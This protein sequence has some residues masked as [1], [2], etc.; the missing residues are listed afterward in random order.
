[1]ATVN[2]AHITTAKQL[3]ELPEDFGP[4]ELVRGELI[5]MT[6]AGSRHNEVEVC[7]LLELGNFARKHRLGRVFSGDAGFLLEED[8]DTVR[9]PDV[10][11]V[12]NKRLPTEL[13][14]R[15]FPRA[16]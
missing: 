12:G 14:P 9:S 13:T 4:C 11:F 1:M 6:P 10:S 8:K 3:L 5:M 15:F 2:T 7:L 16:T